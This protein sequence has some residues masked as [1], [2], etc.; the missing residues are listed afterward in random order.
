MNLPRPGVGAPVLNYIGASY[1]TGLGATYANLFPATTG[2][3]VLDG[4]LNPVAWTHPD[5]VLPTYLRQGSDQASAAVMRAFLDLCGKTTPWAGAFS[6]GPPAATRSKWAT[7]LRR[8]CRHPVTIGSPPQT[9]TYAEVV[10]S[11][12][13]A[14]VTKWQA[15]A[16]WLAQSL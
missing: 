9:Y 6:A 12:P 10:V 4:N 13:L 14:T 3:M 7:L 16:R 1:V 5:G 2:R 8:L 11:V 15:G